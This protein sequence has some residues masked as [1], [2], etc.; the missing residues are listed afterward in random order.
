MRQL[1]P[2]A[3]EA[4][5]KLAIAYIG[6]RRMKNANGCVAQAIRTLIEELESAN[7]IVDEAMLKGGL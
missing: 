6:E 3:R 4:D 2:A 5:Y 1:S 7:E